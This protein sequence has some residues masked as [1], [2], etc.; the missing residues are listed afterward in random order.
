MEI[1][2]AS[3]SPNQR[4]HWLTQTVIPRPIAW[5]LTRHDN[6]ELNLAPFSFFAPVCSEPPT[7][8]VSIG[9]KADGSVKDSCANLRHGKAVV[10][11]ASRSQLL[12]LNQSAAS[13]PAGESELQQPELAD[14]QLLD[15][16]GADLPRI[17]AA[18]VAFLCQWQQQL[19][20]GAAKQN[21]V[22][23]QIER[24]FCRDELVTEKDG[25]HYVDAAQLDPLAR[26][27][28][29]GYAALGDLLE[30]PRP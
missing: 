3:L 24:V 14:L 8:M 25:R 10:H 18:P 4:Y 9:H 28:G 16:P 23:L 15:W 11:I 13:L 26:L 21:I 27:G 5:I 22:F 2:F 12:P 19:S 29:S 1:D 20:L 6:G 7:L 30:K 17:D